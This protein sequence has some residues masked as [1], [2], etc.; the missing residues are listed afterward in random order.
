MILEVERV[1]KGQVGP[2]IEV[3]TNT[4]T[5]CALY[6]TAQEPTGLLA[7]MS[8]YGRLGSSTCSTVTVDDLEHIFGVGYPPD[9]SIGLHGADR[10]STLVNIGADGATGDAEDPSRSL[11]SALVISLVLIVAITVPTRWLL[12]SRRRAHR[13]P[14]ESQSPEDGS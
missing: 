6:L 3:H 14:P 10:H 13:S 7:Y 11:V 5:N 12:V 8:D 1:Y 2:R 9:P 4:E